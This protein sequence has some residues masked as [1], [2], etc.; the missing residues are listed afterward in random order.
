VTGEVSQLIELIRPDVERCLAIE[1]G[2]FLVEEPVKWLKVG[3]SGLEA[4]LVVQFGSYNESYLTQFESVVE[5]IMAWV[6][7]HTIGGALVS[8]GGSPTSD[9]L[10]LRRYR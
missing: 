2:P 1:G 6:D 3:C 7:A 9:A 10:Y 8:G 5:S 4:E